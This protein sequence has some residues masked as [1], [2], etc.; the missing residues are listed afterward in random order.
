MQRQQLLHDEV[1]VVRR[2]D[3]LVLEVVAKTARRLILR[4]RPSE[5]QATSIKEL[6]RPRLAAN[7]IE[8]VQ[9]E[10]ARDK[11]VEY[12][13]RFGLGILLQEGQLALFPEDSSFGP[14]HSEELGGGVRRGAVAPTG[15]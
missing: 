1:V 10:H 12:V 4:Q 13:R 5:R 11:S 6:L 8:L 3:R 2:D 7:S 14:A 15:L 9:A